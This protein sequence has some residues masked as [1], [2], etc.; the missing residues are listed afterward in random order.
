M[1]GTVAPP[2]DSL[3]TAEAD[4]MA[5][6]GWPCRNQ[7]SN[8]TGDPMPFGIPEGSDPRP[9]QRRASEALRDARRARQHASAR[10]AQDASARREA[11]RWR[12]G[13]CGAWPAS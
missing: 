3:R 5:I 1:N 8:V 4:V 13:G 9:V 7:D 10:G 6:A 11:E 12:A 2:S